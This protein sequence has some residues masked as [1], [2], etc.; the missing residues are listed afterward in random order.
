MH[1]LNL[2]D[3]NG[4]SLNR[5]LFSTISAVFERVG[6]WLHELHIYWVNY[7]RVNANIIAPII[8][9]VK[10]IRFNLKKKPI[11]LKISKVSFLDSGPQ[12]NFTIDVVKLNIVLNNDFIKLKINLKNKGRTYFIAA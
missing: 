10:N 11:N 9:N 2:L 6:V 7:I 5:L 8:K 4:L 12:I 1:Y 3:C